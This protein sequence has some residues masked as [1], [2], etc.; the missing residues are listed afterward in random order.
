MC[1]RA[2]L[3]RKGLRC[4]G[5][6]VARVVATTSGPTAEACAAQRAPANR[7]AR[8]SR[9]SRRR[10]ATTAGGANA[11]SP[12]RA[13]AAARAATRPVAV[14]CALRTA[15][16]LAQRRRPLAPRRARLAPRRR[17]RAVT[18]A[19][20]AVA[21]VVRWAAPA[22]RR[23]AA[24]GAVAA[25]AHA[26]FVAA[27]VAAAD[28][29]VAA[30]AAAVCATALHELDG[31]GAALEDSLVGALLGLNRVVKAGGWRAGG[32]ARRAGVRG[33]DKEWA[34]P[35]PAVRPKSTSRA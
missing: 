2:L 35:C 34:R 30:A 9:P 26:A 27:A 4:A 12:R 10:S 3:S 29:T 24:A 1:L 23:A 19:L 32:E 14:H 11:A 8:P 20:A 16:A 6:Q 7:P 13:A 28:A 21:H 31:N 17:A 22:A 33:G 18:A 25:A 5:V 15:A